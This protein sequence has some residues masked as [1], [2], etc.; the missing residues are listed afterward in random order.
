MYLKSNSVACTEHCLSELEL[1]FYRI[2]QVD[3]GVP[4][5][6]LANNKPVDIVTGQV[7]P[8]TTRPEMQICY[9]NFNMSTAIEIA[10]ATN[11]HAAFRDVAN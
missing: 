11:T 4:V 10:K 6:F 3:N 7:Q 8:E 9:F 2:Q 5:V 1:E